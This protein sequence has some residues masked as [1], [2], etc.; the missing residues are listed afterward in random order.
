MLNLLIHEHE[1]HEQYLV[2]NLLN[3]FNADWGWQQEV[4]L[5]S[6][7]IVDI[8]TTPF[9]NQNRLVLTNFL[10]PTTANS[11][12]GIYRTDNLFSRWRMQLGMR[13]TF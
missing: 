13:Y 7:S 12:Q 1:I 2:Q 4:L 9:D 11:G 3:L 10:D 8:S 6:H 5:G